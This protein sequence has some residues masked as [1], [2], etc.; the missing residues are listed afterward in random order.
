[1]SIF[2][3]EVICVCVTHNVYVFVGFIVISCFILTPKYFLKNE[4]KK[5]KLK[6]AISLHS[7]LVK[8]SNYFIYINGSHGKSSLG[9]WQ[10]TRKQRLLFVFIFYWQKHCRLPRRERKRVSSSLFTFD[11]RLKSV[12]DYMIV[13]DV[14]Q[15]TRF[16]FYTF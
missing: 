1:M 3:R 10:Y 15:P 9:H 2:N 5:Q 13:I 6:H 12:D 7:Y 16:F 14:T 4:V 11:K 8:R